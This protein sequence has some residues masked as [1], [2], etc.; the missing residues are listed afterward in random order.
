MKNATKILNDVLCAHY[1]AGITFYNKF[2]KYIFRIVKI[3]CNHCVRIKSS[4]D[5]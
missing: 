2:L 4:F 3:Y 1:C 5:V